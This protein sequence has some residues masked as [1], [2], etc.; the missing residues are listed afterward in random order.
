MVVAARLHL[1]V[2]AMTG[3][4]LACQ[5]FN[6]ILIDTNTLHSSSPCR[7]SFHYNPA[8]QSRSLLMLGVIS[9]KAPTILITK[10]LQVLEETLAR[11]DNDITLLEAVVLCLSRLVPLL[12]EVRAW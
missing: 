11:T 2:V 5:S 6:F 9:Q 10:T 3:L 8:L 7:T 1:L 4:E 12:D